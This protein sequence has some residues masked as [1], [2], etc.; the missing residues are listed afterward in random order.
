M[1]RCPSCF[2]QKQVKKL[3]FMTGPCDT[4]SAT[5][6]VSD[7]VLKGLNLNRVAKPSHLGQA[8]AAATVAQ[9][10]QNEADAHRKRIKNSNVAYMNQPITVDTARKN[11][12]ASYQIPTDK[13]E[14]K[15]PADIKQAPDHRTQG[16]PLQEHELMKLRAETAPRETDLM[17]A[18][19]VS[20]EPVAVVEPVA[21]VA[22]PPKAK[23]LANGKKDRKQA[24]G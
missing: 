7:E 12:A 3:G 16:R 6:V 17:A 8:S 24:K 21:N 20:D 10:I 23:G 18:Q 22:T 4:C 13:P 19:R 15:I 2:G 5:G 1:N 14:I 9:N 11:D